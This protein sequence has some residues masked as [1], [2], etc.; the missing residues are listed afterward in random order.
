MLFQH[1]L[2]A[3]FEF[4]AELGAGQQ[5]GQ[6]ERQHALAAQALGHLVIDD[7]LGQAFDNGSLAYA[8]FADQH[9][10]V[11]GPALQ[12]L[13]GAADFLVTADHRIQL[14]ALGARGQV[15]GVLFQR[16]P[17]LFGILRLNV[18]AATQLVDGSLQARLVGTGGAQRHAQR[19]A[20][21]QRG[22][23]EPLAGN[24]GI[25]VLLG[26]LVGLVQQAPQVVAQRNVAGLAGHLGQRVQRLGQAL[27]QHR[28]VHPGLGQQRAR[29][30]TLL[31]QQRAEQVNRFDD[32]VV[33][34][35]GQR[36]CVCQRLLETRGPAA[37]GE[38]GKMRL[39]HPVSRVTATASGGQSARGQHAAP[40]V[41]AALILRKP[42]RIGHWNRRITDAI[43]ANHSHFDQDRAP[44]PCL[45]TTNNW[46]CCTAITGPGCRA[47]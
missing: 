16:L 4:A 12:H 27:A 2:Q 11:L 33:A 13:D 8:G 19:A 14:A 42:A 24:E 29:A 37:A 17:L 46:A 36:L 43:L 32:A 38:A 1:G 9:R 28:H 41:A 18:L 6:V 20:I 26:Q 7:A 10:V 44:R 47:G 45:P 21:L 34:A 39:P 40:H 35:H 30:A 31:V 23:H 3:F 5:R 15:D 25:T 22:Q